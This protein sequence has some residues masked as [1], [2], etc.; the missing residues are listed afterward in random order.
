VLRDL[1]AVLLRK[2]EETVQPVQAPAGQ[3]LFSDGSLCAHY[4]L[5]IEGTIWSLKFSPGGHE[6]LYT[7]SIPESCAITVVALL[8]GTSFRRAAR[9][10]PRSRSSA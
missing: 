9:P 10:R 5:L 6:I 7:V 1:P 3:Q 4:P 2:V 8:G